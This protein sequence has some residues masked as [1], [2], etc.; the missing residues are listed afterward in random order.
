MQIKQELKQKDTITYLLEWS[1]SGMLRTPNVDK[2]VEQKQ[3]L[4]LVEMQNS[5]VTLGDSMVFPSQIKYTL[6]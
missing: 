6:I 4:L 2:D 1:K 5:I 3:L